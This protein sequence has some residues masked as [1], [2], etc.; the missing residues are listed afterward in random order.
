M[1]HR[2][3]KGDARRELKKD[4]HRRTRSVPLALDLRDDSG[5]DKA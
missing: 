1:R 4:A 2:P 5:D 3:F